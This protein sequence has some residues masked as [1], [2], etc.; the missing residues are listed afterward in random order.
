MK[1]ATVIGLLISVSP[2]FAADDVML[3]YMDV[4][5]DF[6]GIS[7][8]TCVQHYEQGLTPK[9]VAEL[10]FSQTEIGAY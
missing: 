4:I 6:V 9:A 1:R 8:A 2:A 10:H 7:S 5:L 3:R